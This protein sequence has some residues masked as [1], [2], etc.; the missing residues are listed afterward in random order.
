MKPVIV[1]HHHAES[2]T[3][4]RRDRHS[5]L[6]KVL[7]IPVIIVPHTSPYM[8]YVRRR[9]AVIY[10]WKKK[11]KQTDDVISQNSRSMPGSPCPSGQ[12]PSYRLLL[13]VEPAP[14]ATHGSRRSADHITNIFVC[15]LAHKNRYER[16]DW[17]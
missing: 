10:I 1:C 17:S 7:L 9:Q 8:Y 3:H 14:T 4:I 5:H 15:W 11:K 2:L 13:A 16:S 6:I 12:Q